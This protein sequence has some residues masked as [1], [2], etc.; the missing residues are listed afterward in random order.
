MSALSHAAVSRFLALLFVLSSIASSAPAQEPQLWKC[1]D[2]RALPRERA[3]ERLPVMVR[4]GV[5][6]VFGDVALVLQEESDGIYVTGETHLRGDAIAKLEP[7]TAVEVRGVTGPGGFAPVIDAGD[8]RVLGRADLP[9]A[10]EV[11]LAD[12]RSGTFDCHRIVIRG[13]AQR[14]FARNEAGAQMRIEAAE[15]AGRFSVFVKKAHGL[16]ADALVDAELQIT[17]ICTTA[18]NPRGELIGNHVRVNDAADI[19]IV[20]P[21]STDPFAAP[22][23]SP[24][25]LRPFQPLGP[26]LHRQRLAGTVT[27]CRPG[28]FFYVQMKE[29]SVRVST[30]SPEPLAPG[31]RVEA[32]GFVEQMGSFAMLSEAVFR[33]T[34]SG[35]VPAPID[36]T[37]AQILAEKTLHEK[38]LRLEDYDGMLVRMRGRLLNVQRNAGE[39]PRLHLDAGDGVVVATLPARTPAAALERLA[40]GSDVEITGVCAVR[41]APLWPEQGQPVPEDFSMLLTGPE[42]VRVLH[43]PSWWTPPRL[44]AALGGITAVLALALVWVW[45]LRRTVAKQAG[46]I[47]AEQKAKSEAAVEFKATLRERNRLAA[48]LHDT[49]EQ[50][51]TAVALQLEAAR[52]L[53][54]KDAA[55]AQKRT[56]LADELLDRSRDDLRR[57]VWSLRAGILEGRTFADALRELTSRTERTYGV[58]CTCQFATDG[59][60]VPEFEANHLLLLAQEAINNA[61]KHANP[62]TISIT[63]RIEPR[64]ITMTVADDGSGF[65]PARAPGLKEGH[66]GLLGM[67]ERLHA[68]GG[69]LDIQ[70]APGAGTRIEVNIPLSA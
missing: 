20:K 51:L 69:A 23:V 15:L 30:R 34:G 27:F 24:L 4:G 65:D 18:F 63:G 2:I 56:D 38:T 70:S 8:I 11:R 40:N 52:V 66:F 21:A 39:D 10:R 7:G 25:A 26:N 53:R 45:L 22:E 55:E 41:L 62:K 59:T 58:A 68:L 44:L 33:R 29:R 32:S 35:S 14:C 67:K 6:F 12:L 48:D 57:S 3:S 50:G 28:E 31:D 1:R 61:L 9:P 16:D 5:T 19:V 47:V 17:G 46:R 36:T 60:R 64:K 43:A 54:A 37:R 13:V 49:L 42:A